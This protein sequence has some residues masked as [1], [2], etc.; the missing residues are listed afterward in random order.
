[1][2]RVRVFVDHANFDCAWKREAGRSE[3][4]WA[5]LPTV[6]MER[7]SDIQ[8]LHGTE[9][10]HR[11]TTVYASTHPRPSKADIEDERW[12]RF[13]LDQLPGYTVKFSP[14]QLQK[15]KC[16]RGHETSHWVEKG[17]DTKIACDML[18]AAIRDAYDVAVIVSN[19]A[20]LIPSI[21]CVQ[22][23][24]DRRVVHAGLGD[25]CQYIR[26]AAWG[27]IALSHSINDLKEDPP[28]RDTA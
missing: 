4:D 27:H 25:A 2:L 13:T 12:L 23:V 26:S 6:I 16:S 11:G 19:D 15:G 14:R 1:M 18:A 22:D 3:L 21:E 17:V 8:Y 7:L 9:I 28:Q 10:E 5:K 20:D 24:L